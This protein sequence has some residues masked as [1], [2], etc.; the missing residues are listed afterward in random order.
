MT[1]MD[2]GMVAAD[3]VEASSFTTGGTGGRSRKMARATSVA[4]SGTLK[5]SLSRT[6]PLPSPPWRR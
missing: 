6:L 4:S 2:R 5:M 3:M 1:I